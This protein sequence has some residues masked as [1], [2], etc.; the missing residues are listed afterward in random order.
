MPKRESWIRSYL[1][2]P[3][4]GQVKKEYVM[5]GK[6]ALMIVVLVALALVVFTAAAKRKKRHQRQKLRRKRKQNNV[7]LPTK[8]F[9]DG[10]HKEVELG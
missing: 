5:K 1:S 7:S 4:I 10:P 8:R 3:E 6:I 2:L 9:A